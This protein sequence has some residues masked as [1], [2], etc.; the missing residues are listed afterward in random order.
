MAIY[1]REIL[2]KRSLFTLGGGGNPQI[3]HTQIIF[4][5]PPWQSQT[6]ILPPPPVLINCAPSLSQRPGFIFQI[7]GVH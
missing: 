1:N 7:A 2:F 4:A 3:T 5:P 6:K